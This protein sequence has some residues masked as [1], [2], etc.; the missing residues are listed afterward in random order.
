M[1]PLCAFLLLCPAL[2]VCACG[3]KEDPPLHH[4]LKAA[5]VE[6]K[7]VGDPIEVGF[8]VEDGAVYVSRVSLQTD[9]WQRTARSGKS[10]DKTATAS[11]VLEV[12][13]TFHVPGQDREPSSTV[14]LR[15][16]EAEGPGMAAFLNREPLTGTL[17]HERGGRAVTRSLHLEGGTQA[18]QLEAR[19]RLGG[20]HM[21]GFAGSPG[22]LPARAVR[23]GEAW[24]VEGFIRPLGVDNAIQQA[25]Q[26]GLETPKPT[27]AGTIRVVGVK[28]SPA[29][30]LL[31]LEIDALI[32]IAGN[33]RKDGE[34]GRMSYAN[35]VR[36]KAL[37]SV[38]TGLPVSF[39][40]TEE[41]RMDVR[42]GG[43]ERQQKALARISGTVE[44]RD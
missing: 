9:F 21:A 24:P 26:L 13:Q 16:T 42:G 39:E 43:E 23:V 12:V 30:R 22:W 10:D 15:Y 36:C 35:Q 32:E 18:E 31:E 11:A 6:S 14:R 19:N 34:K 27:L 8:E 29:G 40:G 7:P 38:R 41:M 33:Y 2:L 3:A 28:E 17:K 5:A 37:V 4:G 20:L 25:R 1:R 44:R